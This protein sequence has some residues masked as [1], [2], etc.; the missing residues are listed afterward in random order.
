MTTNWNTK[1]K[2]KKI[3][4]I[5][6]IITAIIITMTILILNQKDEY[7]YC[8]IFQ[9]KKE[10]KSC[11]KLIDTEWHPPYIDCMPCIYLSLEDAK[12][13]QKKGEL[14]S[15]AKEAGYPYIAY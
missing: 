15:R 6:T 3:L 13:C 5:T 11:K 14:C 7:K 9:T 8:K 10:A 4:I 2:H 12:Y 1:K